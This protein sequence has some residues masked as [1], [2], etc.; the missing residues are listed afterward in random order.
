M[1]RSLRRPSR[2]SASAIWNARPQAAAQPISCRKTGPRRRWVQGD[3]Y[4]KR[5]ILVDN[6]KVGLAGPHG[7]LLTSK[8]S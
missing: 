3:R 8:E 7:I 1:R 5:W 2:R 6:N 4:V